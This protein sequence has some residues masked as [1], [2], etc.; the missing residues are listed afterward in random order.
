MIKAT[1]LYP[2]DEGKHFDTNYYLDKHVPLVKKLLGNACKKVEVEKGIT[3]ATP[4]SAPAHTIIGCLYFDS[5]DDFQNSFGANANEIVS[6][7]ANFTN[8]N[9]TLQI[10]EIIL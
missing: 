8:I 10:S 9:P 2:Y 5:V 7:V 6:D 1:V 4:G 3:G